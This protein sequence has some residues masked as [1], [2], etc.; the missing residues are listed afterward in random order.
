MTMVTFKMEIENERRWNIYNEKS[1]NDQ[2]TI[3]N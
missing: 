2:N 1:G 3:I